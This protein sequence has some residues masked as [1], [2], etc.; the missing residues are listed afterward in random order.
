M[1]YLV[2]LLVTGLGLCFKAAAD[3]P[4]EPLESALSFGQQFQRDYFTAL[5]LDDNKDWL[6]L[7]SGEVIQ[8]DLEELYQKA[9][10][11]DS[12]ELGDLTIEIKDV[13]RLRTAK[14]YQV[15][16]RGLGV[17]RG[18]LMIDEDK[19]T[20]IGEHTH[21]ANKTDV[22]SVYQVAEREADRW[23]SKAALSANIAR[24]NTNTLEINAKILSERKTA[25]SRTSAS[26]LGVIS[27]SNSETT[28]RNHRLTLSHDLYKFHDWFF[29]PVLAD[30]YHAPLKN[31]RLQSQ[32]ASQVGYIVL[33]EDEIEW[34]LAVGPSWQQTRFDEVDQGSSA[35]ESSF[36]VSFSSRFEYELNRD[37]EFNHDYQMTLT[38]HKVGGYQHHNLFNLAIDI[39]DDLDLDI[40]FIW[41]Y[42]QYPTADADG[43]SPK[44]ND[45]RLAFG[46]G[47]DF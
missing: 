29:R 36:G 14:R 26:Y 7:D 10:L 32:V 45:Y 25:L 47:L 28:A 11:F 35:K 33:E 40:D 23:Q 46:I 12:D 18:R 39:T 21:Y 22:I 3:T 37:I 44:K 19:L 8:G 5:E 24:G 20:I 17:V 31:I 34:E 43:I 41:D 15:N 16:L 30:F 9:L 2:L 6:Q 1:R 13:R 42:T 4:S 27:A 38:Q